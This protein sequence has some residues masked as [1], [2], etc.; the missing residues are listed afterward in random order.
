VEHFS[1]FLRFLRKWL[2]GFGIEQ[3][4]LLPDQEL[5]PTLA[6]GSFRDA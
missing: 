6:A 5:G 2:D 4:G 1:D 3:P